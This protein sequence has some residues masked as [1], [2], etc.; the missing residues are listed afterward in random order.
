MPNSFIPPFEIMLDEQDTAELRLKM[1][2]NAREKYRSLTGEYPEDEND[3]AE[4]ASDSLRREYNKWL[5]R[6]AGSMSA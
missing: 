2:I 4:N 3:P 1:L 5:A 6:Q